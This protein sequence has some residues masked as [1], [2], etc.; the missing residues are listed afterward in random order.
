MDAPSALSQQVRQTLTW[1]PC[2][3]STSLSSQRYA[4]TPNNHGHALVLPVAHTRN[5]ADATPATRN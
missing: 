5:L 2:A 3:Q 1:W 4:S